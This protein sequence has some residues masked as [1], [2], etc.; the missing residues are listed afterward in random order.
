MKCFWCDKEMADDQITKDHLVSH[1][2]RKFMR[3]DSRRITGLQNIAACYDCNQDRSAIATLFDLW[4]AA[5]VRNR[6]NKVSGFWRLR[7]KLDQ[8]LH[9]YRQL[10]VAKL[11]PEIAEIVVVEIDYILAFSESNMD[12]TS[13]LE[14]EEEMQRTTQA[15]DHTKT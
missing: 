10:I 5:F 12:A 4:H 15:S 1:A 13:R 14:Y 7:R 9:H 3:K 11:P 8:I 2:L 6:D